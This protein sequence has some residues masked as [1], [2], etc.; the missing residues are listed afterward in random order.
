MTP[1]KTKGLLEAMSTGLPFPRNL[2][3]IQEIQ[4]AHGI[5]QHVSSAPQN[6]HNTAYVGGSDKEAGDGEDNEVEKKTCRRIWTRG[7]SWP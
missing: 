5:R 1:T 6:S 2:V 4:R 3:R 7:G